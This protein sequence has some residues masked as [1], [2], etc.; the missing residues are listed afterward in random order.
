ML[1]SSISKKKTIQAL[2]AAAK[3]EK[4]DIKMKL[5]LYEMKKK[6]GN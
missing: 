2:L 3:R 1:M 5:N 4:D 6:K